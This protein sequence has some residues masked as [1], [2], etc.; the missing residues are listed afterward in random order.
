MSN[1]IKIKFPLSKKLKDQFSKDYEAVFLN[2]PP[3]NISDEKL[4]E[5]VQANAEK[6][7]GNWILDGILYNNGNQL[8]INHPLFS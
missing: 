6:L 5:L 8:E 3:H 7:K 4:V 2:K 1:E